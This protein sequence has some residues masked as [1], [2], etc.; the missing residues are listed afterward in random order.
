MIYFN[1]FID[2]DSQQLISDFPN[3]PSNDSN[4]V[5]FPQNHVEVT[6]QEISKYV[7][8]LMQKQDEIDSP[9]SSKTMMNNVKN[10]DCQ[11]L[12][13]ILLDKGIL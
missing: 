12:A 6:N 8:M 2:T 7:D 4:L 13:E 11:E 3:E 1:E 10:K 9:E 5:K